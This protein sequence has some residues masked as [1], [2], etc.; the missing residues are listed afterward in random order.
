[1]RIAQI[2]DLHYTHITWNPLR[3]LSKRLF[4]LWNWVLFREKEFF[5]EQLEPLPA[6]FRELKVDLVLLGGDFSTTSLLEEFEL[7]SQL[8]QQISQ[9]WIAIPGNHDH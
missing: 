9:P 6:L 4:G 1:M 2:S 5:P 7:A 3:F 8:I